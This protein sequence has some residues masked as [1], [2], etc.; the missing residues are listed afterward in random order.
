[1][2][3]FVEFSLFVSI[4]NICIYLFKLFFFLLVVVCTILAANEI[5]WRKKKKDKT[6]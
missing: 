4:I 2:E 3:R 1:M 5:S 6:A